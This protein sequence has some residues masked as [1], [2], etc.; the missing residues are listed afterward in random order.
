MIRNT[1]ALLVILLLLTLFTSCESLDGP[2]VERCSI[3]SWGLHCVKARDGMDDAIE[4]DLGFKE[5]KGHIC[6]SLRSYQVLADFY[7]GISQ[8]LLEYRALYGDLPSGNKAE[9]IED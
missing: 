7:D 8:E 1:P 9:V 5:A 6:T 4:W 2:V 3:L